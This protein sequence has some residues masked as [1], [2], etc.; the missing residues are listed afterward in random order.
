MLICAAFAGFLL[1]ACDIPQPQPTEM[2][3]QP[4]IVSDSAYACPM[5][6]EETGK[7][8]EKCPTCGM[9][10][11]QVQP[12]NSGESK[13][14][15][16][17]TP[18]IIEAGK[19]VQF[20]FNISENGKIAPLDVVHEKKFHLLVV[21][22]ALTWF[23]HIHPRELQGGTYAVTETF[24]AGGKYLLFA[25]YKVSGSAG[26]IHRQEIE[27]AGPQTSGSVSTPEKWI[28][29][30]EG[31]TVTLANGHDFKT[32]RPQH[33]GFSIEKNGKNISSQELQPYLGAVAHVILIG[34]ADKDFLH[35]HP[36]STDQ[37]PIHGETRFEKAGTYQMWVQFQLD[38]KVLTV[39]F[40]LKVA[41][42]MEV[43]ESQPH[44]HSG[45]QL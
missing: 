45:H 43:I 12:G 42:G 8:G 34:K 40:T 44:D 39:D 31:Y 33:F 36:S 28:S 17:S 29:K 6:P 23:D 32:R 9:D 37:F 4:Q 7:P 19:P 22:E 10:F 24:P 13:M 20:T 26:E 14:V 1:T 30:V 35:V 27:V 11:E 21:N 38:G 5:H 25:D 18:E 3:N 15:V 41:E 16:H 2:K